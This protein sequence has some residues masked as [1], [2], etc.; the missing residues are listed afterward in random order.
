MTSN[1]NPNRFNTA[2]QSARPQRTSRSG[3]P[4]VAGFAAWMAL[5]IAVFAVV[6]SLVA[7]ATSSK[8]LPGLLVLGQLVISVVSWMRFLAWAGPVPRR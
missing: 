3:A 6:Y 7:D 8:G 1:E 2:A 5:N 4:L